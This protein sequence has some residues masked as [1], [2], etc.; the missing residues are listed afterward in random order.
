MYAEATV[1]YSDV[2]F[3]L[4]FSL[5]FLCLF[6]TARIL[7]RKTTTLRLITASSLGGLYAFI[8]YLA[9]MKVYFSLPMH[10]LSALVIC[11]IA[12]VGYDKFAKTLLCF[13]TASALM[14]GL[15]TAFYS[16]IGGYNIGIYL[17]AKPHSFILILILSAL[18]AASFGLISRKSISV[19][20]VRVRFSVCGEVISAN[21]LCDIGNLVTEP[22]S[23]LPV[24]IVSSVCL[25]S[26]FDSPESEAFPLNLRAV[27]CATA[28][29]SC[30]YLAFRPDKIEILELAKKPK[31]VDAYLAVDTEN[32]SFSGYDGIMPAILI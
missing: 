20:S 17:D 11:F 23:A 24:I 13:I 29:G 16:L 18:I 19:K 27:P 3:L 32:K 1:I 10:L 28:R 14:G 21:L 4:N 2:L 26:P 31:S 5:D 25:P 8:P 12:F 6:I 7:N 22:F 15:I 30:C 9:E